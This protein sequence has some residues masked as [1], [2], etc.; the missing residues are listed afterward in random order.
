MPMMSKLT[1]FLLYAAFSLLP[2]AINDL[3]A[4]PADVKFL[5][6]D[7]WGNAVVGNVRI[8]ISAIGESAP[9]QTIEYPSV[10]KTQLPKGDYTALAEARGF[11]RAPQ[12][13]TVGDVPLFVPLALVLAPVEGRGSSETK[14]LGT[15]GGKYAEDPAPL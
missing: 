10:N 6:L 1:V 4:Q 12:R 8:S 14:L 5:V 2:S 3:R 15:L 9:L 13:F 7:G 11:L